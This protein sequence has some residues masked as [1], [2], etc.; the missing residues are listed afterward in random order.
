M[1]APPRAS[2][3]PSSSSTPRSRS[4]TTAR[5]A[6]ARGPVFE[7]YQAWQRELEREP[8]DFLDRR[9]PALLATARGELAALPRRAA[10]RPR[11]RHERDDRRQPRRPLARAPAGRR[12]PHDRPR[13]RR[14]RPRLGV[15]L[16]PHRRA[17]RPRADPAPAREPGESS[18]RSSP[19][20]P[21]GRASSTSA[22]SR[23]RPALVLPVEEI[24]A[25]ARGLGLVTIVDGAHAPAHV[26]VDL[27][28]L[29]AD[30]YAGNCHKWL[31]PRRAPASSTSGPSTRSGSTRA[32]VSWGYRRA[33]LPGADRDAGNARPRGVAGRARRDPYQAERDWDAVRERCR[34]LTREARASSASCSELSR[35]R[36]RRCSA[37]WRRPPPPPRPGL[38]RRLFANTG[39][40]IPVG[41][42][43]GD[44]LR[45]SVA[46]YTTREEVERLLAA[47]V[48]ELDAEHRQRTSSPMPRS[49]RRATRR[50]CRDSRSELSATFPH[51]RTRPTSG[52]PADHD[53][54]REKDRLVERPA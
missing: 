12:G 51:R 2:S 34:A 6:P 49:Q 38:S 46:A 10:P 32:I 23:P 13:V 30:F 52:G 17:L 37:R 39:V 25:R 5:S 4:S 27:E 19:T 26:P 40:E 35:S 28:A 44:L 18:T 15:A 14:L 31:W 1:T 22:T 29:G 45:I 50:G 16:P 53:H 43:S 9:L 11:L 20:R 36:P 3:A 21:S 8:V 7:R 48:R 47:L 54:R 41:G 24:V 33:R 42:P